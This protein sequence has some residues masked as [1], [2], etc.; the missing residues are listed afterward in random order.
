MIKKTILITAIFFWL[1]GLNA[2]AQERVIRLSNPPAQDSCHDVVARDAIYLMPGYSFKGT[3][4][5]TFAARIDET[6]LLKAN[7]YEMNSNIDPETRKIDTSLPVGTIE[8]RADVSETGAAT[9]SMPV[10]TPQGIMGMQPNVSLVYNSQ[11]GSGVLGMGWGISG[12]SVISRIPKSIFSDK[13]VGGVS[14][15]SSTDRYALDGNRLLALTGLYGAENTTYETEIKTF[16]KIESFGKISFDG[17]NGTQISSGPEWFKVTTK[18]GL[19]IE[20]GKTTNAR[21]VPGTGSVPYAWLINRVTDPNGNYMTYSYKQRNGETVI[22]AIEYT[23]NGS[24][25]PS[26]KILFYYEI[27]QDIKTSYISGRVA[28]SAMLLRKIKVTTEGVLVRSYKFNYAFLNS[29]IHTGGKTYLNTVEEFGQDGSKLNST[30][31]GWNPIN[32]TIK[33]EIIPSLVFSN[34]KPNGEEYMWSSMDMNNDGLSDLVCQYEYNDGSWAPETVQVFYSIDGKSFGNGVRFNIYAEDEAYWN[35]RESF[36][37]NIVDRKKYFVNRYGPRSGDDKI[38]LK[39]WDQT[40]LKK[41]ISVTTSKGTDSDFTFTQGDLNNDGRDEIFFVEVITGAKTHPCRMLCVKDGEQNDLSNLSYKWIKPFSVETKSSMY[42]DISDMRI[43]QSDYNADGLMD[44]MVVTHDNVTFYKNNGSKL[45]S[46]GF[47]IPSFSKE[48]ES[49]DFKYNYSV[50][51]PGDFNGDGIT[52]FILNEHCNRNWKLA[53]SNGNWGF[54]IVPLPFIT[55]LE[56]SYTSKNDA[57]EQCLVVDFNN[58]G[59]SDVVIIDAHYH[60]E[61]NW[62]GEVWYEYDKTTIDWYK[63]T[64]NGLST[65]KSITVED[66]NYIQSY[67]F[68]QGDFDGDGR[69]DILSIGS[70]IYTGTTNDN[71][72]RIYRAGNLDYS[73]G[74]LNSISDG[75][76]RKTKIVYQPLSKSKTS[77]GKNF[78]SK[79]Q[80]SY[81]LLD[82]QPSLYCVSSMSVSNGIGGMNKTNYSYSGARV[83]L[84]GKGFLGFL[85]Q[86]SENESADYIRELKNE[87]DLNTY[88]LINQSSTLWTSG[89]V[90]LSYTKTNHVNTKDGNSYFSRVSSID[91][92]NYV[93]GLETVL[94]TT[95][96]QYDSPST[97]NLYKESEVK[98]NEYK[99]ETIYENYILGKPRLVTKSQKHPDDGSIFS[100]KTFYQYDSKGNLTSQIDNYGVTGKQVITS[101]SNFDVWGNPLTVKTEASSEG[102]L[103]SL[104]KTYSYIKGRYLKSV[105]DVSGKIEYEYDPVT[106]NLLSE[107]SPIT[108]ALTRYGYDVWGRQTGT[109]F[110]D[111]NK[112]TKSYVWGST[113]D[114][115]KPCYFINVTSTNSPFVKTG[116]DALGREM[117]VESIGVN[118]NKLISET[119]YNTK[120]EVIQKN[121]Y[122]G[123]TKS[124]QVDYEYNTD[125][126]ILSE[127]HM[128]GYSVS[129]SY[130]GNT[131]KENI[132][133]DTYTK[134]Y[135]PWGGIKNIMEPHPGGNISYFYNSCGKPSRIEYPGSAIQMEYDDLGYQKK[136]VDPTAGV[137]EYRYD[138]LGRLTFQLDAKLYETRLFYD[139]LGRLANK[140]DKTGG[141]IITNEYHTSGGGKGLIQKMTSANGVSDSYEYDEFARPIKVT[142]HIDASTSDM[143][144]HYKYNSNGNLEQIVYP[145]GE[146]VNN[147]YD[148]I[149]NLISSRIGN[150]LVWNLNSANAINYIY[151]LGNGLKTVKS[152]DSNGLLESIHTSNSNRSVQKISYKFDAKEGQL[153]YHEVPRADH[154]LRESFG[155]DEINRLNS[156]DITKIPLL[157]NSSS[158]DLQKGIPTPVT[159]INYNLTAGNIWFKEGVG[160][161]VYATQT[162]QDKPHTLKQILP[163]DGSSNLFPDH[164]LTYTPT[165]KVKTI[166]QGDHYY[167]LTYGPDDQRVKSELKYQGKV[168]ETIYYNG[169][170]ELKVKSDGTR[171]QSHYISGGEGSAALLLKTNG[172]AGVL[173]YLHK[174][175]LGSIVCITDASGNIEEQMSY[176]AWG[177][178]R[179]SVD[180]TFDN[181]LIPSITNRG[182]TGHEHLDIFNL[183]N[184][185]GRV[186]DPVL[187][188]FISPD[189]FIQSS[190]NSQSFNRY[191]YCL[192]NPL[193]YNDPSGNFW[194]F[195]LAAGAFYYVKS[196]YDNRD[197]ETGKWAWNPFSSTNGWFNSNSPG[198]VVG[199]SSSPDLSNVN[200]FGG[201]TSGGISPI[202]C[203]STQNGFGIGNYSSFSGETRFY[204]PN[205]SYAAPEQNANNSINNARNA[206]FNDWR[207]AGMPYWYSKYSDPQEQDKLSK[208]LKL[209]EV[210]YSETAIKYNIN[211]NPS[212]EHVMALKALGANLYDPLFSHFNGNIKI[213]SGYRSK[214]LNNKVGGSNKS[215]HSLGEALDVQGVN[216]VTNSDIFYYVKNHLDYHQ[217]IWEFGNKNNPAWVHIGYKITGNKYLQTRATGTKQK[218]VYLPFK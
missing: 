131:V 53:I 135:D 15:L 68:A 102:G 24:S 101:Y 157:I 218:P 115:T 138:G 104:T 80:S 112:T 32:S 23:G 35:S 193:S 17:N 57:K 178:R 199:V 14:F 5:N 12:L 58:D 113:T 117:N 141:I 200:V 156:W 61:S 209:S 208:Y 173:H 151:T 85:S 4:A 33:S 191:A 123:G 184:M 186:Y 18:E 62:I 81:P 43:F 166:K 188:Q 13:E 107:T 55:A 164:E 129:Y 66:P 111:G 140:K 56:E 28:E 39:F 196:A 110:P 95:T 206:Y 75:L 201:I 170:Y 169:S 147:V 96:Y 146:V 67:K 202:A 69:E 27:K 183:I 84:T 103:Y 163:S 25:A 79:A 125:G 1:F 119:I 83:Q 197:K 145:S 114:I 89:G 155:Y 128:N 212:P 77:D 177:R 139:D 91:E 205:Y 175:H 54:N 100:S 20:Y 109:I 211:N 130:E 160:T 45:D 82:I 215:Q 76:N 182:Y 176:D 210:I 37:S 198:F 204:Y 21:V 181:V 116:Y 92:K 34:P 190:T 171:Q 179:N 7:V 126:S 143:V 161:Y 97:G 136:L 134:I 207:I 60:K 213:S 49:N 71:N 26:N 93:N 38:E 47:Y 142:K 137:Q 11:S 6:M 120:G 40:G 98:N 159:D 30:V 172:A 42:F 88:F 52:D 10:Y 74:L 99:R 203:F 65:F 149:G 31:F 165:G 73:E 29:Y 185:N 41:T 150:S 216:G 22:E 158:N 144:F 36:F 192:N 86:R 118:Y 90:L 8:G 59:M 16:S 133:G 194:Q 108:G 106:L 148:A 122:L 180:W 3:N 94:T 127:I 46:E 121:S 70:D 189:N 72:Y 153:V 168:Q 44:I 50:I 48:A 9:Y 187:G 63:S 217:I 195:L 154:N 105:S 152:F 162:S 167:L 2:K 78:Y 132:N 124:S 214:L 19:V 87:I 174:D 51:R 64:K